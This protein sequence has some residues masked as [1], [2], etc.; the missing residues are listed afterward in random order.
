LEALAS[1]RRDAACNPLTA[2]FIALNISFTCF[3]LSEI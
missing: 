1:T 3:L 2:V